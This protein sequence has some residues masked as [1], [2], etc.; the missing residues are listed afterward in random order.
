[1]NV[2]AINGSP[3]KSGNTFAVLGQMAEE[4]A[5]EGID[6]EI[7]HVG[8]ELLHGCT[9]CGHCRS[10]QDNL[11]VFTNDCLNETAGKMRRANGFILGSPTY[12]GGI[13]GS[14]KCFLDRA[15]Y[16]SSKYFKYKVAS[17]IAVVRRAGSVDVIH[18]LDNYLQLSETLRPPSQYWNVVYGRSDAEVLKDDEGMQTVRKNARAMAWLLKVLDFSK[19]SIPFPAQEERVMTNFIR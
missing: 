12:Y 19:E 3:H 9:G 4:L 8:G 7:L 13:S 10:A 15:F 11:C 14:M 18:Q 5:K 6:T 16:S 1:M 17:G 2:I